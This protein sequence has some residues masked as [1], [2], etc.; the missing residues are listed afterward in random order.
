[1]RKTCAFPT[2]T[3][4]HVYT[5]AQANAA[6]LGNWKRKTFRNY[7]NPPVTFTVGT[8]GRVNLLLHG[9]VPGDQVTFD[10]TP[11]AVFPGGVSAGV[12]YYVINVLGSGSFTISTSYGAYPAG[13][14]IAMTGSP[15]GSPTMSSSNTDSFVGLRSE[16]FMDQVEFDDWRDAYEYG[17]FRFTP[18]RPM[19]VTIDSLKSLRTGPMPATGYTVLGDY[20]SVPTHFSADTDIPSLPERFHMLLVWKGL[21]SYG[22]YEESAAVIQRARGELMS[23]SRRLANNQLPDAVFAGALA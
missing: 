1:M 9:L 10:A 3:G 12:Q 23:Y 20:F 19:V 6:D 2:V 4:Q 14:E 13:I 22:G 17:A 18:T 15:T 16:I 5:A 8:P 7:A 21:L 11:G